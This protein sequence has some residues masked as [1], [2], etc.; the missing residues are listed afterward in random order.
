MYRL[1]TL[2]VLMLVIGDVAG[3]TTFIEPDGVWWSSLSSSEQNDAL[4]GAV[5]G[6]VTAQVQVRRFD[7]FLVTNEVLMEAS[8]LSDGQRMGVSS[9]IK[10]AL[11]DA[12][13]YA[14]TAKPISAYV[15]AMTQFY[16]EQPEALRMNFVYALECI[17]DKPDATCKG[18]AHNWVQ[19]EQ[20]MQSHY[21]H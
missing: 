11:R 4:T 9:K 7:D 3:A 2:L 1:F 10:K 6:Y 13:T 19:Q 20:F 8:T 17:E 14:F 15:N 21:N 16:S 12:H 18:V 5:N